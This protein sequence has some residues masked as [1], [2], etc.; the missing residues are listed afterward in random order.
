MAKGER[1]RG[2]TRLRF[3]VHIF[4]VCL[5]FTF[6]AWDHYLNAPEYA[7]RVIASHLILLMGFLFS[8]SSG[9]FVWMLENRQ[10]FLEKEVEIRSRRLL[11][12]EREARVRDTASTAICWL[13]QLVFTSQRLDNLF[14]SAIDLVKKVLQADNASLMLVDAN[15][16]LFIAASSGLGVPPD[17]VR[18]TRIKFGER[19][20]GRAAQLRR[21]FLLVG[22]LDQYPQFRDVESD[23]EIGSAIVCPLTCNNRVVGV[24]NI[25]RAKNKEYFT[26]LHLRHALIF[27]SQIAQ[28]IWN[29]KLDETL[30]SKDSELEEIYR[31]LKD[32]GKA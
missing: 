27:A 7:S 14:D 23:P 30:A 2:A 11:E 24:L 32:E 17:V 25:N 6:L 13:S 19:I 29:A 22:N 4:L 18:S 1:K 31:R 26:E 28:T 20:A 5:L 12:K 16:E 21:E 9:L 3:S 8:L 10:A 15:G